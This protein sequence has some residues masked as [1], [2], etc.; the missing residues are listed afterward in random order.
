MK[1]RMI[2]LLPALALFLSLLPCTALASEPVALNVTVR[3]FNEDGVL[4]EGTIDSSSGLVQTT[5]A[6]T[7]SLCTSCLC[8]SRST[9][10]ASPKAPSTRFSTIPPA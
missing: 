4:F 3:D 8:G 7:K 1:K 6:R 9:A 10:K 5:L 2:S